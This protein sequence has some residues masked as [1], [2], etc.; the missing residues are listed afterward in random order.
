MTNEDILTLARAGFNA[1]QIAALASVKPA[2]APAAQAAAPAAQA[3]APAAPATSAAPATDAIL[4]KLGVLTDAIQGSALLQ[5]TQ[6]KQETTDD[7][8]ASIIA[9]PRKPDAK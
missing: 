2:A 9:P 4:A 3:A 1:Q 5:S 8:L 6:P 7:I